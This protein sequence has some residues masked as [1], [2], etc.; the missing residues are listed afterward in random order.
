[1]VFDCSGH[2]KGYGFISFDSEIEQK[3]CLKNMNG[4]PGLGSKPI[5]VKN[6]IPKSESHIVV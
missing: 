5:K 1:V 3:H 2:S 4:F 6:V